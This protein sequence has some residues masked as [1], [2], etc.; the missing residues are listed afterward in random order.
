MARPIW[1][2]S[3]AFGLVNVPV[4]LYS[5]TEDKTVHFHQFQA[6]TSDRIRYKRVNERTGDEVNLADIVRGHEIGKGDYVLITDEELEAVEPGRSRT[7]EISDFVDLGEIDPIYFQKTY[8]L[9]P[10]G[11]GAERAYGLLRQAMDATGK[12][13]VATFVMRGKQYLVAIRPQQDV[14]MLETMFF[15][16]E[17]RDPHEEL[18]NLP[19]G[20]TFRG[21]EVQIAKQLIESLRRSAEAARS[22]R[23]GGK[24][25]SSESGGAS[26]ESGG[27]SSE[28]GES[29]AASGGKAQGKRGGA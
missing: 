6:G 7:I 27:A 10:Q 24:G 9:A 17:V 5:A 26:S 12:V 28:S 4:R 15:A 2:G 14:L 18:D 1:T 8:Y 3:L 25:S 13:G 21:R 19:A 11:E 20:H 29:G 23:R 22:R 16:D